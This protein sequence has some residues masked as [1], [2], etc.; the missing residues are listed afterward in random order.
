M[1]LRRASVFSARMGV[2]CSRVAILSYLSLRQVDRGCHGFRNQGII[3]FVFG[4]GVSVDSLRMVSHGG[5]KVVMRQGV[6]LVQA[7]ALV[8]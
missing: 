6:I 7:G 2:F 5:S 1:A 8:E 4:R 3:R